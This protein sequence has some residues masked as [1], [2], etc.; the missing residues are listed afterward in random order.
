MISNLNQN[1]DTDLKTGKNIWLVVILVVFIS[2]CHYLV[3]IRHYHYHE[4]FRRLY[5]LPIILAAYQYGLYGGLAASAAVCII[6]LPHVIF[7]WTG[8]LLNNLVRFTEIIL[9][10]VVGSLAGFLSQNVKNERNRYKEAAERLEASYKQLEIQRDQLAEMESQ[11]RSADRLAVMGE[12]SASLAHEVRNPLGSIKGAVDIL[13]KRCPEDKIAKEFSDLLFKEVIR[14]NKVVDSYLSMARKPS[15]RTASTDLKEIIKSVLY[16]VG[17]EIRKRRIHT[18]SE[19]SNQAL[20]A[21]IQE[22][23]AQQ[24]FLNLI[25]NALAALEDDGQLDIEAKV[26]ANKIC[27]TVSDTGKGISKKNISKIFDP[28]YTTRKDGMGL[29]LSIVK[30]IVQSN[31]GNIRVESTENRGTTFTLMF[32]RVK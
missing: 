13:R 6:Y 15:A 4:I 28:F 8:N 31:Q 9:Y 17:P 27:V 18:K 19:F 25:L 10:L 30:R 24:V 16:L 1:K 11:L 7:Q 29:G 12:L 5:Y 23:E 21:R 26:Q 22:I 3:P 32:H 20:N 14:L 2:T